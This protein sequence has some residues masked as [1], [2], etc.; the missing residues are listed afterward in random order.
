MTFDPLRDLTP[1]A[2][3]TRTPLILA[4]RTDAPFK[5][6][7]Q[8]VEHARKT[9]GGIRLGTPGAGSA[10]DISAQIIA[11]LLGIEVTSIPYKG[12]APAVTDVLGGH[13]EGVLLG[14]GAL[15]GH[16]KSGTLKGLA[17]SDKFAELPSVPT[18][19]EM[20][21][22][23]DLQGVWLGFFAPAG[24]PADVRQVLVPALERVGRD[25][26]I[27]ARL[28]P[29]GIM[30]DYLP[31][32]ELATRIAREFDEMTALVKKAPARLP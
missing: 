32:G 19:V 10:G 21:Y 22:G 8:L 1:L 26:A 15:S 16:L 24:I 27:A 14:L 12:A 2:L 6:F 4:A 7:R 5:D 9:P 23:K 30:Q 11:S 25:D 17:I 3:T 13:I 20:G 31:P 18:L 28:L 29:L